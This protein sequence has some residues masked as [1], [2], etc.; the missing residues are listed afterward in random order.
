MHLDT[1]KAVTA[2]M[3]VHS[4]RRASLYWA[5]AFAVTRGRRP[6]ADE[7][8]LGGAGPAGLGL[9]AV[10]QALAET[11]GTATAMALCVTAQAMP[12]R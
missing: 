4:W 7:H 2:L 1:E 12:Y 11:T 10:R 5:D 3:T 9:D 6:F 8:S